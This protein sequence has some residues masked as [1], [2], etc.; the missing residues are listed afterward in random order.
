MQEWYPTD[1]EITRIKS[2]GRITQAAKW[3][4]ARPDERGIMRPDLNP[5]KRWF[6]QYDK[7]TIK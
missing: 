1:R 4:C 3:D 5:H 7:R 6:E 2:E